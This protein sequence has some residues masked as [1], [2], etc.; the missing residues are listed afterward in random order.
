MPTYTY[1]CERCKKTFTVMK[2]MSES[3]RDEKCP[4]CYC[5]GKKVI[6]NGLE[7]IL[8]GPGFY[9]NDNRKGK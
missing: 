9:K 7:F 4:V 8:K 5:L 2:P 6:N 3:G 1:E